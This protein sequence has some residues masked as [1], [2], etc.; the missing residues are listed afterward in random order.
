MLDGMGMPDQDDQATGARLK[1]MGRAVQ[2]GRHVVS[3]GG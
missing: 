1:S 2:Q 3:V